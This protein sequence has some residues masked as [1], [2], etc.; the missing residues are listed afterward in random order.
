[1]SP[2]ISALRAGSKTA[3]EKQIFKLFC[4]SSFG[5]FIQSPLRYLEAKFIVDEESL[6]KATS[7]PYYESIRRINSNL[8]CSIHKPG[9]ITFDRPTAVGISILDLSKLI[10]FR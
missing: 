3:V 6:D 4:N 9:S 1:M 10:V 2:F 5:K 8:A 7:S